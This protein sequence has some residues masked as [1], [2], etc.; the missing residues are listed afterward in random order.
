VQ[1][2]QGIPIGSVPGKIACGG[3]LAGLADRGEVTAVLQHPRRKRRVVALAQVKQMRH[4]RAQRRSPTI[5]DCGAQEHPG[6]FLAPLGQPGI[7]Q[8][9]NMA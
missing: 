3:P 6:P 2:A 7:A 4:R 5:A 9:P 1:V 8:D